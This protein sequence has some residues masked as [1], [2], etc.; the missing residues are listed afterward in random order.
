MQAISSLIAKRLNT[1]IFIRYFS[2]FIL[3]KL[4]TVSQPVFALLLWGIVRGL[5]RG[6]K[7]FIQF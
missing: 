7:I 3:H 2:F 5:L 4:A 1:Y 6:K